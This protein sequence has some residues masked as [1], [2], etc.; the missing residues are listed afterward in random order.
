MSIF[1]E[2]FKEFMALITVLFIAP[3]ILAWL[4]EH[5]IKPLVRED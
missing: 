1:L 5:V 4:W 2:V 3:F